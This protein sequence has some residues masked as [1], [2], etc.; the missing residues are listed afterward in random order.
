M[1]KDFNTITKNEI[2]ELIS[3]GYSI[4]KIAEKLNISTGEVKALLA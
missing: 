3:Q 2:I 4:A 1:K